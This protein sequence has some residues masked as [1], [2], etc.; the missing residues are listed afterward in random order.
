MKVA[1][2]EH[3]LGERKNLARFTGEEL[4][5]SLLRVLREEDDDEEQRKKT[6]QQIKNKNTGKC[7]KGR[8]DRKSVV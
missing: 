2:N 3:F 8:P 5:T 4:E 6:I 1:S 7:P